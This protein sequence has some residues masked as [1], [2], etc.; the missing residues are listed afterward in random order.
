MYEAVTPSKPSQSWRDRYSGKSF[1][2]SFFYQVMNDVSNN[3]CTLYIQLCVCLYSSVFSC[4][5]T[6][7]YHSSITHILSP[8][9]YICTVVLPSFDPFIADH[10]RF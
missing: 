10:D 2:A 8:S 6:R 1:L 4:I 5:K 3:V 7:H 9:N